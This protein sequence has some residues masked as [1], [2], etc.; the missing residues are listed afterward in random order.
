MNPPLSSGPYDLILADPPWAY[1]LWNKP[2]AGRTAA[3][4]YRTMPLDDICALPVAA[5]AAEDAVLLLWVT[6]PQL[7]QGLRVVEAWGFEYRDVLLT[8]VTLNKDGSPFRGLGRYTRSNAELC[9]L[10]TRGAG[11]PARYEE[12]TIVFGARPREHS[13]TPNGQYDAVDAVFS[14][15]FGRDVR[16]IELFA[17]QA[18]AGWDTWGRQRGLAA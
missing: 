17:R 10:A 4:S 2:G 7:P 8:W 1:H 18:W 13:R 12:R 3:A 5:I 6:M 16:R 14:A 11:I 15:V 9:L